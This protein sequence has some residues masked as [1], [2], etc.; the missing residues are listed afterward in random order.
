MRW[1]V[2]RRGDAGNKCASLDFAYGAVFGKDEGAVR[3]WK[4]ERVVGRPSGF[5]Q[6]CAWKR[7]GMCRM[8]F[9]IC[10]GVCAKD[11]ERGGVF[12]R[13]KRRCVRMKM[14]GIRV[15]CLLD[16]AQMRAQN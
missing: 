7:R 6:A 13:D 8:P 16:F 1:R 2:K 12:R 5:T 11:G 3:A 10:A 14:E 15:G 4:R 9:G